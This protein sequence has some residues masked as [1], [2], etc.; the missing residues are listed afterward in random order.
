MLYMEC[1]FL[2]QKDKYN[3]NCYLPVFRSCQWYDSFQ[4]VIEWATKNHILFHYDS[5]NNPSEI[6]GFETKTYSAFLVMK[7]FTT[8]FR[9]RISIFACNLP[10][11]LNFVT[12][13]IRRDNSSATVSTTSDIIFSTNLGT[14]RWPF[15]KRH[16]T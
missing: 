11:I 6:C 9:P 12:H 3:F 13:V 10:L 5:N 8:S 16:F 14:R 15:W 1:L 7:F 4:S 2:A